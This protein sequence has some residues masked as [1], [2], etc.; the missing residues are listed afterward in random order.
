MNKEKLEYYSRIV[1]LIIGVGV[2]AYVVFTYLFS[3]ILPF[4]ISWGIAMIT[5][6][7]ASKINKR[8]KLS[9]KWLRLVLSLL[10]LLI[11]A[12]IVVGIAVVAARE[13][14]AFLSGIAENEDVFLIIS[15]IEV[16]ECITSC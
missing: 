11:G 3:L 14:W 1:F 10:F 7:P 16:G 15:K 8:M 13:A 2:I 4:A 5:N 6:S 12:S 9:V